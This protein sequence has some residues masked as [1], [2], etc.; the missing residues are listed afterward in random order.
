MSGV[1]GRSGPNKQYMNGKRKKAVIE[2]IKA[3]K[4]IKRVQDHAFGKIEMSTTQIKAAEIL[5]RKTMPDTRSIEVKGVIE[6][7]HIMTQDDLKLRLASAGLD[8][9]AVIQ[10]LH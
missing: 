4:L 7:A 2:H 10:S 6:H 5:L 1:K 8:P 9:E 3:T